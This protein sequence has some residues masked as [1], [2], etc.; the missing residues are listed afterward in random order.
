M[1]GMY[2]NEEEVRQNCSTNNKPAIFYKKPGNLAKALA[3]GSLIGGNVYSD[4]FPQGFVREK[5]KVT[6]TNGRDSWWEFVALFS[7]IFAEEAEGE[8]PLISEVPYKDETETIWHDVEYP[9]LK[10]KPKSH[11]NHL[12]PCER[13]HT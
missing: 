12:R 13:L 8:V 2:P 5:R 6:K 1:A 11:K 7:R 4:V 9:A 3:F 10:K